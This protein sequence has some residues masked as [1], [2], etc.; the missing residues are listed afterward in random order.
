[1]GQTRFLRS[2][3]SCRPAPAESD[4]VSPGNPWGSGTQN[5]AQILIDQKKADGL[6]VRGTQLQLVTGQ[7]YSSL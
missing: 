2:A 5:Q 7:P 3:P 4:D 6:G 1:M